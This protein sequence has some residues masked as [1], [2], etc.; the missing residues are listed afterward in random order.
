MSA[1]TALVSD[2]MRTV[3]LGLAAFLMVFAIWPVLRSWGRSL[4][5]PRR[6]TR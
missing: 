5:G 6:S 4:F 3:L 2:R 1:T